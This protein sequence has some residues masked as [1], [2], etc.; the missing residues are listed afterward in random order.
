MSRSIRIGNAQAFWGDRSAAAAE[1]LNL[2]PE[3]DYL[4]LDYLAEV[5]MSILAMQRQLN[6][7]LGYARDF[8]DVI[9]SLAPYW[10]AGGRCRV[11]ANAGGLNPAACADACRRALE[12]EGCPSLRIGIVSGDDVLDELRSSA[13]AE[14]FKNLDDG[15]SLADN[16]DRIVTANAYLGAGPIAQA[17]ADGAQIVITGRVADPSLVV[18]ACLHHFGWQESELDRLAG[19]T[20]A[21][22]LIE[23]GTQ[24]TGGISTDWLNVPDP[25]NIG[26]PIV[27]VADSGNCIVSKPHGTGGRVTATTVREQLVYEIGD[28]RDYRS[29]GVCVRFDGLRVE[30]LGS[31]RVRVSGAVGHPRPE[32]YKV[33]ATLR[34]GFRAAGTLVIVGRDAVRKAKRCGEMVLQRVSEAGFEIR[35]SVIECLGSGACAGSVLCQDSDGDPDVFGEVV[36]RIAIESET[37]AAA[38]RFARELMPL[39]TAGPQG[40]TGYAEGRPRV[41]PVIR[42]WPCLIDRDRVTPR[43]D[44]I[45]TDDTSTDDPSP[46]ASE[47]QEKTLLV[48]GGIASQYCEGESESE[49]T[50]G[51]DAPA[52]IASRLGSI[53]FARSG[54]KGTSANIGV[55][56]RSDDDWG[57]LEA[58]LTADRVA[59][60]LQP[61][62]V[63]SVERYELKNLGALNFVIRGI[64]QNRLRSDAQGKTLGQL[65]LEMP[66][67]AERGRT[68][69]AD[70]R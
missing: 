33:S 47:T 21:G 13:A 23:C 22:H 12:Q 41:R 2:E 15:E 10:A 3:L 38:E 46:S 65:L 51:I 19:A 45:Q 17:L 52:T 20:V 54:D 63:Q 42:Y 70:E 56:L 1:M 34:D 43:V 53:A 57:F 30:D 62:G 49:M 14:E 60:F 11:L 5:S 9:R 28:P 7:E 27:E 44:A 61:L 55:L 8:V 25:A 59:A 31:N 39:I 64:L 18:A 66:L 29:P 58:W 24:V 26:F 40:T 16:V 32:Q 67:P 37:Q 69:E 35:D 68:I 36:L 50:T 6:P 4:T 48:Q